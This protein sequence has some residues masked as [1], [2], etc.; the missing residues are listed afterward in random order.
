M[1]AGAVSD[2]DLPDTLPLGSAPGREPGGRPGL[3]PGHPAAIH[4]QNFEHRSSHVMAPRKA[5]L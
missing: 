3:A 1:T 5:Q 2:L 4:S